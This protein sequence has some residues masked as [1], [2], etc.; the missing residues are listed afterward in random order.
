MFSEI[1]IGDDIN[2]N[3]IN[4]IPK[5]LYKTNFFEFRSFNYKIS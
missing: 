5:K 3:N 4:D 1:D 2:Q